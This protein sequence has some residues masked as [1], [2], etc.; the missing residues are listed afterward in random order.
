MK[1]RLPLLLLSLALA[2]CI[3]K[4][5][6]ED[7]N[8]TPVVTEKIEE[9]LVNAW[10]PSDP[11]SIEKGEFNYQEKT[12]QIANLRPQLILQK[13]LT[14]TDIEEK[15]N[16]K[17]FHLVIQAKEYVDSNQSKLSTRERVIGVS[18]TSLAEVKK[19]F[20]LQVKS[21]N[22]AASKPSSTETEDPPP[23]Q[24][25]AEETEISQ[26]GYELF[27]GLLRICDIEGF[28]CYN[29][30]KESFEI[31]APA[32]VQQ[33]PNCLEL[34]NCKILLNRISFDIIHEEYD[35]E[36]KVTTKTKVN[37]QTE[38]SPQAPFFSRLFSFC[39]S[40]IAETPQQ[41]VPVQVCM[42]T[43]DFKFREDPN[44]DPSL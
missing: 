42:R 35:P 21:L 19:M 36:K 17:L 32:L 40:G 43:E 30:K 24:S 10:G 5:N 3:K 34:P 23:I 29:L 15:P 44:L 12:V 22:E 11:M 31:P 2:S 9:N 25:L 38:L 41:K 16:Q 39:Y 27:L 1:S 33:R 26:I 37:Y 28:K 8:N 7:E 18:R 4:P 6:I 14:V 20:S 13:A